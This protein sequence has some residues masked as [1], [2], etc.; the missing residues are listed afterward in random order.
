MTMQQVILLALQASILTTVFTFGLQA[1][2]HDLLYVTRRPSLLGRSLF[3]MLVIMP[4]VVV[5]D[6]WQIGSTHAI[7]NWQSKQSFYFGQN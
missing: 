7:G 4:I 1:T 3:A 6:P 5:G 2:V